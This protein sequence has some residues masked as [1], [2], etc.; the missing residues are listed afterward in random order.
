MS[1]NNTRKL[2]RTQLPYLAPGE[3][4]ERKGHFGC[5]RVCILFLKTQTHLSFTK[6]LSLTTNVTWNLKLTETTQGF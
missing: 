1:G 2:G 5:L 4:R 3:E 6:V